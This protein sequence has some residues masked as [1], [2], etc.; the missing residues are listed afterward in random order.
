MSSISIFAD[1]IITVSQE[2]HLNVPGNNLKYG[3]ELLI[4]YD[5]NNQFGR[6]TILNGIT[7]G[8]IGTT[9]LASKSVAK[10]NPTA[11]DPLTAEEH[12]ALRSEY[13]SIKKAKS[14]MLNLI[15]PLLRDLEKLGYIEKDGSGVLKVKDV[16]GEPL[17]KV[18]LRK[19]MIHVIS[20][21]NKENQRGMFS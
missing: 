5:R 10:S 17:N 11:R 6:R 8:T 16:T 1:S 19:S 2:V 15:S 3:A 20:M 13:A 7:A 4:S 12:E 18:D 9:V 14:T 21:W